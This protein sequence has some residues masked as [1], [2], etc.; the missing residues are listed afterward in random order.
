MQENERLSLAQTGWCLA[1]CQNVDPVTRY[2]IIC[3]MQIHSFLGVTS[4]M[5]I[6]LYFWSSSIQQRTSGRTSFSSS[7]GGLINICDLSDLHA[8]SGRNGDLR[9]VKCISHRS[10]ESH[11]ARAWHVHI[12]KPRPCLGYMTMQV[13]ACILSLISS[14]SSCYSVSQLRLA[15]CLCN[16]RN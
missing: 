16:L 14:I 13:H 8:V 4:S 15:G 5:Q 10:S 11:L 9:K 12:D 1:V 6:A 3:L 7:Q 2:M